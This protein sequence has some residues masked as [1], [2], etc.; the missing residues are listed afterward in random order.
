MEGG[1]C[2]T[3]EFS[4]TAFLDC[5]YVTTG[6][7]CTVCGEKW[8]VAH[9]TTCLLAR[10]PFEAMTTSQMRLL[11]VCALPSV[12]AS[13][14]RIGNVESHIVTIDDLTDGDTISEVRTHACC[15]A[16]LPM[17]V[18][19]ATPRLSRRM[20]DR[21]DVFVRVRIA[22][23]RPHALLRCLPHVTAGGAQAH[24][25]HVCCRRRMRDRF[26]VFVRVRIATVRRGPLRDANS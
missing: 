3:T 6:C 2:I 9:T 21:L 24:C 17:H 26:D 7:L 13:E 14:C 16:A 15:N 19:L 18:P 8:F 20:R 11:L 5:H 23:V 22:T 12:S 4:F 10:R 1:R 25:A